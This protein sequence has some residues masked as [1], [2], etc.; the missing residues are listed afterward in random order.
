MV[1]RPPLRFKILLLFLAAALVVAATWRWW[2]PWFG[3]ALVHEDGP[4][5]ADIAVVLAGDEFGQRIVKAGELVRAGYVPTV[6]VS[7]PAYYGIHECDPEIS[8]AAARGFPASWF[9][10]FP[11]SANSTKEEASLILTEL[12]R[13]NVRT[14]LLVTSD[15]HSGRAR[16]IF[17][18]AWLAQGGGPAMRIV[19]APAQYFRAASWWQNREGQKIVFFEWS[20]SFA[21]L[22]GM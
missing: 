14:F 8:F 21:N 22:V 18:A 5:N 7:G 12:R 2:L 16:R 1:Q 6:L 9:I 20:K 4:A 19:A 13:R 11:H 17:R 3:W 15:F 10:P